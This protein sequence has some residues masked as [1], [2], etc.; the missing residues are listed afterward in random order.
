MKKIFK[1][2]STVV[3]I[4]LV[5]FTT[6]AQK[7]LEKIKLF[8]DWE[9]YEVST[10]QVGTEG[11]KYIKVWGYGKKVDRA[12]VQA[13]KNAIHACLFRGIP[14]NSTSMATPAIIRDP[15]ILENNIDYFYEFFETAGAYLQYVNVTTDGI[16]SGQDRREVKGG[17]KVAIKVQVMYDNLKAKMEAEGFATK[18]NSGF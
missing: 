10:I 14:G 3:F 13:K 18:L 1:T 11:T 9:N 6:H 8:H 4:G 15:N 12:I 17:Y 7:P 16:P 2:L 5:S